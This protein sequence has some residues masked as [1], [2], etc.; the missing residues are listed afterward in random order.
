[1]YY[2]RMTDSRQGTSS[3][4]NEALYCRGLME[5]ANS[6]VL[7]LSPAGKITY[8][9]QYGV[10]F[11]GFARD[12]LI[13]QK[14]LGTILPESDS[15]GRRYSR[16]IKSICSQPE[17]YVRNENEN[18]LRSGERVWI[19]W[20]N[21][22]LQDD[23][24]RTR[25]ILSV[26][27]DI[28]ARKTLEMELKKAKDLLEVKVRERTEKLDRA[29][30]DL[31]SLTIRLAA[32][33]ETE[34]KRI[35]REIHDQIGQNLSAIGLNLSLIRSA[36]E[37]GSAKSAG[38]IIDDSLS[39]LRETT[40]RVRNI[41]SDLRL[42]VLDDYGLLAALK[43][44]ARQFRERTEID[45]AVEGDEILPRPEAHVESTFFLIAREAL[46]NVA[47][48][49]EATAV[50]VE[51]R[52]RD[53]VLCL[54]VRDDGKGYRITKGPGKASRPGRGLLSMSERAFL[55]GGVCKVAS[56]PGKGTEVIVEVPL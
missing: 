50:S 33:E 26:G 45:I 28:T 8:I 31:R 5:M 24:G 52:R 12:E 11:F 30:S 40:G 41:L 54:S 55:I 1:M 47:K 20:T 39:L 16:L 37:K 35:S 29:Y 18:V 10:D 48:H 46:A 36:M 9:N 51:V 32:A 14:I 2:K 43:W 7:I 17:L 42:P 23:S 44:Y 3:M 27:N 15:A 56:R 34:K 13:G 38:S 49:A 4:S 25:E 22:A 53:G 6:I 21:K 19:A